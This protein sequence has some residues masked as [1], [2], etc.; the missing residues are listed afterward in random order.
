MRYTTNPLSLTVKKL[1]LFSDQPKDICNGPDQMI[2]YEHINIRSNNIDRLDILD[3]EACAQ[4][5]LD[6][7]GCAGFTLSPS[8]AYAGLYSKMGPVNSIFVKI[9]IIFEN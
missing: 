6:V 7:D 4:K 3:V 9:W 8:G 2:I 1:N 5:C